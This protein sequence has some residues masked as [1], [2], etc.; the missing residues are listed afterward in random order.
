MSIDISLSIPMPLH[1]IV[2]DVGWWSGRDGSSF[3]QPYRTGMT[4]DHLPA[5]YLALT[6]LGQM[7][8]MKILTGFVLCEWDRTNLLR[9]LPSST[10][11]GADWDNS[12]M[13]R[14]NLEDAAGIIA[15]ATD[16]IEIALHGIGHEYW[17]NGRMERAEFHDPACRMRDPGEI[18]KHLEYFFRLLEQQGLSPNPEVFIPPAMK[19][20]FGNGDQGFQKLLNEYGIRYVTTMFE[21]A[22]W[23]SEPLHPGVTWE[24]GVL[25]VD[26]GKHELKWNDTGCAPVFAFDRPLLA[27]HWTNLLRHDP[28][29]NLAMVKKWADFIRSG[30]QARGILLSRS[31]KSCLT[32]YLHKRFSRIFFDG[33]E[34]AIDLSWMAELPGGL[35]DDTLFIRYAGPPE[36]AFVI[37]GAN[38]HYPANERAS[39]VM[40]ITPEAGAQKIHL[41]PL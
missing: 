13:S 39:S 36:M 1:V 12:G 24:N 3:N 22:R 40:A 5:D 17:E 8:D 18:R 31:I 11:M 4:R 37:S 30:A 6:A 32:Q 21:K 16:Y 25:L 23:L 20:S 2:E 29:E 33:R 15:G 7:L 14:E 41:R 28:N 38:R 19:H 27:L 10:W 35:L 34:Y 26:R 9:E